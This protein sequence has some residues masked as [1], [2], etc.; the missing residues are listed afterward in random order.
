MQY[1]LT[2]EEYDELNARPN[3]AAT[4]ATNAVLAA[5]RDKLFKAAK[6]KC[7]QDLTDKEEAETRVDYG[8]CDGCPLS[9]FDE[10]E[11]Y[12]AGKA[13]WNLCPHSGHMYSK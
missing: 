13:R 10:N 1:I 7:Y 4:D 12:E 9:A 3:K 5:L 11:K 2:Q 6:F 8:Y